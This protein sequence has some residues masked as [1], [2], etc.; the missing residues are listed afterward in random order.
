MRAVGRAEHQHRR[1]F[2][3]LA[4][5]PLPV[6]LTFF[7]G[8]PS[9][10]AALGCPR[11]G[12]DRRG[13][14][15]GVGGAGL[16][17]K[18]AVGLAAVAVAGGAGYEGAKVVQEPAASAAMAR[19]VDAGSRRPP[20]RRQPFSVARHRLTPRVVQAKPVRS[21]AGKPMRVKANPTRRRGSVAGAPPRR[22]TTS[23]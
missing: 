3:G 14:A 12:G 16:T 4:V 6:S 23:L 9:A 22:A 15:A 18:I 20:A 8:A 2:K 5:L 11:R 19:E 10:A 21:P 1:A 13:T 17:T 7:K